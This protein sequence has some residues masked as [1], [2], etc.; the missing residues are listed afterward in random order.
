MISSDL[1]C[2]TTRFGANNAQG[3][4]GYL[5]RSANAET[6]L[7]RMPSS[8][9]GKGVSSARDTAVVLSERQEPSLDIKAPIRPI[10]RIWST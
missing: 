10:C 6:D 1:I 2:T 7:R 5:S 4:G 8:I 3:A 9:A